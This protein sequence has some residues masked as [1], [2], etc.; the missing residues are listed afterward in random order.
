MGNR[1]LHKGRF[2]KLSKGELIFLFVIYGIFVL[3][4]IYAIYDM[5]KDDYHNKTKLEITGYFKSIN[6]WKDMRITL[7]DGRRYTVS[8]IIYSSRP[9]DLYVKKFTSEVKPG[10]LL[11]FVIFQED[12]YE[13][14][15]I[16]QLECNGKV[17]FSYDDAI[18]ALQRNNELSVYV[19]IGAI[20][21]MMLNLA[22]ESFRYMSSVRDK[23][24]KIS[25]RT[26][27][28][29][30]HINISPKVVRADISGKVLKIYVNQNQKVNKGDSLMVIEAMQ[31]QIPVISPINGFVE[32][33]Y[34]SV[35]DMV[36]KD[37]ECIILKDQ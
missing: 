29:T 8:S 26:S 34:V 32:K 13:Y 2:R 33:I 6:I 20:V 21:L 25:V 11:R 3:I 16:Y 31:M 23:R 18:A 27:E 36:Q 9:N 12:K 1:V 5:K 10:D 14:P 35:G 24:K 15:Y 19:F 37:M 28:D 22:I 30:D 17:Y 4:C 7:T